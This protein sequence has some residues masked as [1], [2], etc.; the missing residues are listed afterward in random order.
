VID[1]KLNQTHPDR[2]PGKRMRAHLSPL[3][4]GGPWRFGLR[5]RDQWFVYIRFSQAA[6]LLLDFTAPVPGLGDAI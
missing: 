5:L 3:A 4:L 2:F 6:A 1:R